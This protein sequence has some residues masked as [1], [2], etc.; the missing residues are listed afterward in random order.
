[1]NDQ[2]QN[3]QFGKINQYCPPEIQL[4]AL[5]SDYYCNDQLTDWINQ[6]HGLP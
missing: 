5:F 2:R 6:V 3:L 1:M 4:V